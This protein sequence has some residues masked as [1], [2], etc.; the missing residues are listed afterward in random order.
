MGVEGIEIGPEFENCG[1]IDQERVTAVTLH[2][3]RGVHTVPIVEGEDVERICRDTGLSQE[4]IT[5]PQ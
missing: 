3:E 5:K 2:S 4:P 1:W